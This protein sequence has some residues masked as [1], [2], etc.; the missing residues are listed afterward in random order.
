MDFFVIYN[1]KNLLFESTNYT[2]KGTSLG[3]FDEDYEINNGLKEY[4]VIELEV[5]QIL[6][7]N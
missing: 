5:F 7:D 3:K 1:S 2:T 6:L 4:R